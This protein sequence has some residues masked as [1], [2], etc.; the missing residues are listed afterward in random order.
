MACDVFISYES[1]EGF[2]FAENLKKALQKAHIDSF[3]A[4]N[5]ILS[6][7]NTTLKIEEA[8]KKTSY[9]VIIFTSKISKSKWAKI[10]FLKALELNKHI[11]P[12]SYK[13]I[14]HTSYEKISMAY[15]SKSKK[16][17]NFTN[18]AINEKLDNLLQITFNDEYEL[19]NKVLLEIKK[20]SKRK[21]KIEFKNDP[22]EI[23]Q[24]G[25]S[26]YNFRQYDKAL[27]F[28]NKAIKLNPHYVDALN[29]KGLL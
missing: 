5:D 28:Y 11:I 8:L 18:T 15:S 16:D 20:I 4:S 2:N 27:D 3:L 24:I 21:S 22:E 1:E 13:L 7:D 17:N 25:N 9:Y 29:N 26:F 23:L 14:S 19:A 6:Q 10:E 12:C